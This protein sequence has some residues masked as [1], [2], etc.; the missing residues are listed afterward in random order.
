MKEYLGLTEDHLATLS[1]FEAMGCNVEGLILKTLSFPELTPEALRHHLNVTTQLMVVNGEDNTDDVLFNFLDT[2]NAQQLVLQTPAELDERALAEVIIHGGVQGIEGG[3][4]FQTRIEALAQSNPAEY[5]RF[6][7]EATAYFEI[8]QMLEGPEATFEQ[9]DLDALLADFLNGDGQTIGGVDWLAI[10]DA[11]TAFS[12][13][14]PGALATWNVSMNDFLVQLESTLPQTTFS[15]FQDG[16]AVRDK[17]S[18]AWQALGQYVNPPEGFSNDTKANIEQLQAVFI[19]DGPPFYES[20]LL[21]M[22]D[23]EHFGP[24]DF[25]NSAFEYFNFGENREGINAEEFGN[26]LDNIAL[27]EYNVNVAQSPEVSMAEMVEQSRDAQQARWDDERFIM[28]LDNDFFERLYQY[29]WTTGDVYNWDE[30][31]AELQI[32]TMD[33]GTQTQLEELFWEHADSR[34]KFGMNEISGGGMGLSE[35]D[36]RDFVQA[37]AT[38]RDEK[39]QSTQYEPHTITA[40]GKYSVTNEEMNSMVAEVNSK[41]FVDQLASCSFLHQLDQWDPK[42]PPNQGD[43][44]AYFNLAGWSDE[45]RIEIIKIYKD[46]RSTGGTASS[47]LNDKQLAEFKRR[48]NAYVDNIEQ[49]Y[50]YYPPHRTVDH[51]DGPQGTGGGS[52]NDSGLNT[53]FF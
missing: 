5:E 28:A 51:P 50:D 19:N 25:I 39:V 33:S 2:G 17:N 31:K 53:G 36:Y 1:H 46:V 52:H 30:V 12:G 35:T 44:E 41:S 21:P 37:V 43:I 27:M 10:H 38:L 24:G 40:T 26:F 22:Q 18:L 49:K 45:H 14:E 42:E 23:G 16:L 47:G 4:D 32:D 6:M 20:T 15:D 3:A 7:Q 29:N 11:L 8:K 9:S 13:G 48:V 34:D